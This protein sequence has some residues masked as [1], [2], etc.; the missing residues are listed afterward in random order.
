MPAVAITDHGNM[1]GAI[2]FYTK[3]KDKGIKPI[4]GSEV[5]IAPGSR[6]SKESGNG[7]E[8]TSSYHLILLCQNLQGYKNLSCWF[9]PDTR[10]VFTTSP[11]STKRYWLSTAKD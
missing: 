5:Y 9:P 2:E 7:H 6:F 10:R 3:C 1:F 11:A 4:I 8:S